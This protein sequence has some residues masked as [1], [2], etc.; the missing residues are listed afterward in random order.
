MALLCKWKVVRNTRKQQQQQQRTEHGEHKY[1]RKL[2]WNVS[3]C[4][5]NTNTHWN[6]ICWMPIV[7][8]RVFRI[9]AIRILFALCIV[10]QN[11]RCFRSAIYSCRLIF[12]SV[13][14]E[15]VSLANFI[16]SRRWPDGRANSTMTFNTVDR[17]NQMYESGQMAIRAYYFI[18]S[19]IN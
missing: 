5:F 11:T 19:R 2:A 15:H 7:N 9:A 6:V 10:S 13:E 14:P 16:A 8:K 3:K 17:S 12:T 18:N 4:R 1:T